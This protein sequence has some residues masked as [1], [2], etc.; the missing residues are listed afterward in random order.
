VR[1]CGVGA[2]VGRL[3][4]LTKKFSS[5]FTASQRLNVCSAL[6]RR[7][8]GVYHQRSAR[9]VSSV[10]IQRNNAYV[11]ERQEHVMHS[12]QDSDLLRADQQHGAVAKMHKAA[13]SASS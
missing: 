2:A 3:N 1:S 4:C 10:L 5:K 13:H 12:T 7:V 11:A 9:L 8:A 6:G